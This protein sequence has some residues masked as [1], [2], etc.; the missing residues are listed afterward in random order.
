VA[1]API[2]TAAAD[3]GL[4]TRLRPLAR[5]LRLA[6]IAAV[7]LTLG[8]AAGL[9]GATVVPSLLGMKALTVISGS[10]VPALEVGSLVLDERIAPLDA[11]PGDI[12]SFPDP[13][14]GGMLV[15]HRVRRVRAEGPTAFF[16]T[17]GDANNATE[18]WS[19]PTR[20]EIG[21]VVYHVPKVGYARAFITGRNARFAIL[22]AVLLLGLWVLA[23]VWRRP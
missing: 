21:R 14:R 19:V 16:V 7:W 8:A 2:A 17:K 4:S 3:S 10:M 11:R 18:R 6:G 12:V 9:A 1:A 20:G 5:V 15:T 22:G 23:D 13:T